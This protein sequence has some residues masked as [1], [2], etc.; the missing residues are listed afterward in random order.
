MS[1]S[2]KYPRLDI[3]LSPDQL[4]WVEAQSA[5]AGVNRSKWVKNRILNGVVGDRP[6]TPP[7]SGS[8][9]ELARKDAGG[10]GGD[11]LLRN[12]GD[13]IT[14]TLQTVP[15]TG[16]RYIPSNPLDRVR[17]VAV[18]TSRLM[19]LLN[20]LEPTTEHDRE[21]VKQVWAIASELQRKCAIAGRGEKGRDRGRSA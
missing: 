17:E 6:S 8:D 5:I 18:L 15:D 1:T 19:H 20:Q 16:E 4:E 14:A 2:R 7:P 12:L 10:D 9:H 21:L 13:A 11:R 3:R